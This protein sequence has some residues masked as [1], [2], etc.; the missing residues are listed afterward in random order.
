VFHPI[1]HFV[2]VMIHEGDSPEKMTILF[3]WPE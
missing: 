3:R 2:D 1:E